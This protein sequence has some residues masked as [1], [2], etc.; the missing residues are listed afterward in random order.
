MSAPILLFGG[1]GQVGWELR[2]TL[3]P[4]GA[5]RALER[6][7]VDLSDLDALRSI[8][9]EAAPSLIV[10]AA[11]F[12]A[13]D[14]AE[15][16]AE[17]ANTVNADAPRVLAEEAKR[18]G[19]ALVH[20][21]TDYVFDGSASRPYRETDEPAPANTYGC[22]KLAGEAAIRDVGAAYLILRTSWVYSMRG[23]NF[24]LTVQRLAGEMEELRIVG[25]QHGAPTW[26]RAIAEATA[27]I[28][29]CCGAPRAMDGLRERTGLYHL[30][31]A[32][33]T[34]WHGFASA[35]VGWMGE[36]GRPVRCK[37]IVE[38][39]TRDYPT[40]A[41]RP[42]NSM[43]DCGKLQDTF[44]IALPDWREQFALCTAT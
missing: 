3:A 17:L 14:R 20:F 30:T 23:A 2:R 44:G 37:R 7:D 41:R 40:P 35:I 39:P 9:R 4:L 38:I 36:T 6:S 15:T 29:A 34:S 8:V 27:L 11:A 42:A 24:L 16:Q 31:A 32:G 26:A 18:L 1:N 28:L 22:S 25:D 12:T 43:L 19:G 5:V 13:V 21:S 10:N 33:T